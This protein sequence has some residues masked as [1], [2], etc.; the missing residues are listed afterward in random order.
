MLQIGRFS[1]PPKF[2]DLGPLTVDADDM[3]GRN[4]RVGDCD[5]RLPASD[6]VRFQRDIDWTLKDATGKAADLYKH[7]LFDHVNAYWTGGPGRITAYEDDKRPIQPA[8]QF[9]AILKDSPYVGRLVAGLPPHLADFPATHLAGAEDFLY[10]SKEKFGIAPFIT[11]THVT[12][13]HTLSGTAIITSKDVYSS[14]YFDSSL[15]LTIAAKD[16]Q[17]GFL[18]VYHEPIAR[19]RAQ[20]VSEHASPRDGRAAGQGEHRRELAHSQDEARA[21]ALI[22]A[23]VFI[24]VSRSARGLDA[25]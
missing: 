22:G 21:R 24:F 10:W 23:R 14:R 19:E 4:C 11:V 9:A 18:L 7:M 17:N 16:S 25:Y 3:N 20:G 2:E 1:D 13:T 15:G 6:L 8:V 5:V 12:L